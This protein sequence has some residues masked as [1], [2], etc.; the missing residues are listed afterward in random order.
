[1]M[2]QCLHRPLV[3][4]FTMASAKPLKKRVVV[5][6]F[7]FRFTGEQE[8]ATAQVA[9]FHRSDAVSTYPYVFLSEYLIQQAKFRA[10]P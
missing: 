4:S 1:M 5:S 2:R 6:N 10:S 9:L 7:I 3:A 8:R